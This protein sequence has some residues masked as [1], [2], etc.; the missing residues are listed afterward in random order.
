MLITQGFHGLQEKFHQARIALKA[1]GLVIRQIKQV[2][3]ANRE[4]KY[5]VNLK[6]MVLLLMILLFQR[7][8]THLLL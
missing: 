1:V 2:G 6:L 3:L 7:E 5:Q 8:Q 4:V